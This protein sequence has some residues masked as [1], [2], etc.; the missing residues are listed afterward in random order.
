LNYYK[1][2]KLLMMFYETTKQEKWGG[3]VG[4]KETRWECESV[5]PEHDMT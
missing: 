1:K 4:I 3:W 5:T 2:L